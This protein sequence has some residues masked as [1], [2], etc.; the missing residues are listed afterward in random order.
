MLT[1]SDFCHGIMFFSPL[2]LTDWLLIDWIT[3]WFFVV[4]LDAN[5]MSINDYLRSCNDWAM[6]VS[7]Q[8]SMYH[9]FFVNVSAS[10]SFCWSIWW[11]LSTTWLILTMEEGPVKSCLLICLFVWPSICECFSNKPFISFFWN[12]AQC[13]NGIRV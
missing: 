10:L 13:F 9:R 4:A 8:F 2:K 7:F 11:F 1:I 6:G 12:L 3:D 5:F